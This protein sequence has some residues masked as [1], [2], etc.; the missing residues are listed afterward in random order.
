M[1]E[2]KS[3]ENKLRQEEHYLYRHVKQYSEPRTIIEL[4]MLDNSVQPIT[5]WTT[6]YEKYLNDKVFIID[7]FGFNYKN[8]SV[9]LKIIEK[10]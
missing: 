5:P 6:V 2:I 10:A 7:T 1:A 8:N 9:N 3:N 4:D